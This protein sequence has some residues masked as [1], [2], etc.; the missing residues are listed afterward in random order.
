MCAIRSHPPTR[1]AKSAH[2]S[3][4]Q[5]DRRQSSRPIV[6]ASPSMNTA[7]SLDIFSAIIDD[8]DVALGDGFES[9]LHNAMP[10]TFDDV[11]VRTKTPGPS[12]ED[13][14]DGRCT[15]QPKTPIESP[16]RHSSS[17]RRSVETSCDSAHTSLP[18]P[19]R[20]ALC[21][22]LDIDGPGREL[23]GDI[24]IAHPTVND[25]S[26]YVRASAAT[27]PCTHSLYDL[28]THS[29][30]HWLCAPCEPSGD[31]RREPTRGD[32]ARRSACW[33]QHGPPVDL[34]LQWRAPRGVLRPPVVWPR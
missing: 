11:M 31:R 17:K 1:R 3:R 24:E 8:C 6:R 22:E 18:A 25:D 21:L 12:V 20:Q 13:K 30:T 4:A 5:T 32:P 14:D 9:L 34:R 7:H 33:P 27:E 15:P 16:M 19:K 10:L 26:D 23:L 2:H 28:R 29:I